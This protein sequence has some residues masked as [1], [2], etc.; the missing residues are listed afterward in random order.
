VDAQKV[1]KSQIDD[2]GKT[3]IA[4][5]QYSQPLN[6]EALVIIRNPVLMKFFQYLSLM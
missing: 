1:K 2:I 4:D 6:T 3:K 5:K